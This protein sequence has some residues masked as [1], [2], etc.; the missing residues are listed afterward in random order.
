MTEFQDLKLSQLKTQNQMDNNKL[1]RSVL[2]M[3]GSNQRALEKAQSLAADVLILDLEDAVS[4]DQKNQARDNI[5]MAVSNHNYAHREITVRINGLDSP[6]GMD[7]LVSV[8]DLSNQGEKIHGVVIPKAESTQ[9][10]QKVIDSLEKYGAK[11]LPLWL[12]IETPLGV[13]NAQA[14]A[15]M[16]DVSVLVMGTNDLSKELRVPQTLCREGFLT[17]LGLCVLAARAYGKTVIDGVYIQLDDQS[18]L[19]QSCEQGKRLGFDG[20]TLIHPKQLDTANQI[21]SP[22]QKEADAAE[23][24][25]SAWNDAVKQGKGVVVVDGR[26]VEELH[27]KEAQRVLAQLEV[28]ESLKLDK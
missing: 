1:R 16:S 13:L 20:K 17:S 23:K 10:V 4:P 2:Y 26:L 14:M 28:V 9:Q 18:G 21:F 27:V 25:V 6:W 3:P 5:V 8:A 22:S 24:L 7:D 15:E 19:L 11:H 12:M